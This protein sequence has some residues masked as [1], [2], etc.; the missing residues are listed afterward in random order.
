MC[1]KMLGD[2]GAKSVDPLPYRC[3]GSMLY[4]KYA[5]ISR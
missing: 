4:M 1:A 3:P 2:A 5:R